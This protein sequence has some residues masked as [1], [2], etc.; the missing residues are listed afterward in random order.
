MG[1]KQGHQA[2]DTRQQ[3]GLCARSGPQTRKKGLA[4]AMNEAHMGRTSA[5]SAALMA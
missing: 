1:E 2:T 5:S 3:K 4:I